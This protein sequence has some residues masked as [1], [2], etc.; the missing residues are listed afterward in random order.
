MFPGHKHTL[1]VNLTVFSEPC[2]ESQGPT[3][4]GRKAMLRAHLL[5]FFALALGKLKGK[6]NLQLGQPQ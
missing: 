6:V 5:A 4:L 3:C 2:P 1:K